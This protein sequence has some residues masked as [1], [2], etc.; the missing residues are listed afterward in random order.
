MKPLLAISAV[1]AGVVKACI[2]IYNKDYGN[3]ICS[4]SVALLAL[5]IAVDDPK[6]PD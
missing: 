4:I 3:C 2:D 5:A 1:V 6:D